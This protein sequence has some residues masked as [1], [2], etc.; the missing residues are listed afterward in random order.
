MKQQEISDCEL[1]ADIVLGLMQTPGMYMVNGN[2]VV[3]VVGPVK[4][5]KSYPWTI[6][7]RTASGP[8]WAP[9]KDI[10]INVLVDDGR[11]QF[12]LMTADS[13][14]RLELVEDK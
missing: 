14:W 1:T 5:G 2:T 13:W 10:D 3:D 4:L 6:Q 8:M 12:V 9:I 7:L 11:C